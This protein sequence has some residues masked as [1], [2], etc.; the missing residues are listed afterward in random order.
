MFKTPYTKTPRTV[1]GKLLSSV[2][3][4]ALTAACSGPFDPSGGQGT[5]IPDE[6]FAKTLEVV[7]DTESKDQVVPEK[8]G[9]PPSAAHLAPVE[10]VN[11]NAIRNLPI[12]GSLKESISHAVGAVYGPGFSVQVY[13]GGQHDHETAARLGVRRVGT[14]AHD[15]GHAADIYVI[16][17]H[18]QRVTG[19]VLAPLAQYWLAAGKGGVGLEMRGGGIHL[20]EGRVRFWDYASD[21]GSIT[22]VQLKALID[23][24]RGVMPELQA[25]S[26]TANAADDMASPEPIQRKATASEAKASAVKLGATKPVDGPIKINGQLDLADYRDWNLTTNAEYEFESDIYKIEGTATYERDNLSFSLSGS[27]DS[28]DNTEFSAEVEIR[29]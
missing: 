16:D 4:I 18:G 26:K 14:K 1:R 5:V 6:R 19:D 21:G 22:K 12:T 17:P 10:M 11:Q 28:D 25:H 20:D 3:A 9:Q 29:F 23:G 7:A 13:S 2:S 15:H 27:H 8:L 24:K